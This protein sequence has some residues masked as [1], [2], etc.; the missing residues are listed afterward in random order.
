VGDAVTDNITKLGEHKNHPHGADGLERF[1]NPIHGNL[2]DLYIPEFTCLCPKTGQ[3]D[4]ATFRIRYVP[5]DWC[6]ESKS[7]KL[8]LWSFRD[9]GVFHEAVTQEIHEAIRAAL[10]PQWMQTL[11]EFGVR[12]G[13]YEKVLCTHGMVP[14]RFK[15][16][17]LL[18]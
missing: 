14:A 4:F 17:V 6:V 3:P 11:G 9:R 12:G 8:Y 15:Q 7:L 18:P 1:T 2:V 16:C 13:I 10:S 5:K